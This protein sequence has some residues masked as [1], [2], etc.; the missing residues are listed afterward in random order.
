MT[1]APPMRLPTLRLVVLL[2]GAGGASSWSLQL[3]RVRPARSL[4]ASVAAR[5]LQGL[6]RHRWR[7][8]GPPRATLPSPFP[9]PD[10]GGVGMGG[11]SGSSSGYGG[12]EFQTTAWPLRVMVFIDG[13]WLYYSL[14]G[15]R[16]NCP[17]TQRYGEKWFYSNSV[18]YERLPYLISQHLH[19]QLLRSH[20]VSRFVEVGHAHAAARPSRPLVP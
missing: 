8:G 15:R 10:M 16:P 3:A 20:G 17:I 19:E 13:S 18:A 12:L 9:P 1:A 5:Q 6:G 11:L 2:L 14:H 4:L 7:A